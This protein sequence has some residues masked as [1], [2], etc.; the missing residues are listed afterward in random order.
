MEHVEKTSFPVE[1]EYAKK[2]QHITGKTTDHVIVY[3]STTINSV[4]ENAVIRSS[5]VEIVSALKSLQT[6]KQREKLV[7][8]SVFPAMSLVKA[9]VGKGSCYVGHTTV[10]LR[11]RLGCG[12]VETHASPSHPTV[13]GSALLTR[14]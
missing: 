7:E 2:T 1:Q 3:A 12:A 10:C 6:T 5:L 14:S 11:T 4:R 8:N 13:L 9:D